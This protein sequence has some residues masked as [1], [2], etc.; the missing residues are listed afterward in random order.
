MGAT[1]VVSV[2]QVNSCENKVLKSIIWLWGEMEQKNNFQFAWSTVPRQLVFV[3]A[4]VVGLWFLIS[5]KCL[6]SGWH[7][8]YVCYVCT[9]WTCKVECSFCGDVVGCMFESTL[10]G[11][12]SSNTGSTNTEHNAHPFPEPGRALASF[13]V[14]HLTTAGPIKFLVSQSLFLLNM[15]QSSPKSNPCHLIISFSRDHK[16][17]KFISCLLVP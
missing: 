16:R 17:A 6:H 13:K 11:N 1:W 15:F 12:H 8:G 10:H 2:A 9:H 7:T 5:Q 3:S 4:A 14:D